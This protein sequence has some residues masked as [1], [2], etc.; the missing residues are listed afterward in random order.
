MHELKTHSPATQ[1]E[2]EQEKQKKIKWNTNQ[3]HNM[4]HNIS[5]I[6]SDR[7]GNET[8]AVD[9]KAQCAEEKFHSFQR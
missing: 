2:A 8:R 6:K 7:Y 1:Y 4:E 3:P 5:N 9:N